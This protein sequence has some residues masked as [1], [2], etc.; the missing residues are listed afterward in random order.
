M[1]IFEIFPITAGAGNG[2]QNAINMTIIVAIF[3]SGLS[4]IAYAFTKIFSAFLWLKHEAPKKA[5][6]L[7]SKTLR[8]AKEFKNNYSERRK[9]KHYFEIRERIEM[10]ERIRRKVRSELESENFPEVE[11]LVSALNNYVNDYRLENGVAPAGVLI[12][13]KINRIFEK[14]GVYRNKVFGDLVLIPTENIE[15]GLTWVAVD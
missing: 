10:E 2:A 15:G 14:T 11:G 12:N 8:D 1:N 3:I 7:S 5:V 6:E 13:V 4:I 9:E